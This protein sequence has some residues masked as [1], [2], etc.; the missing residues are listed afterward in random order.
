MNRNVP[1]W[2]P[3]DGSPGGRKMKEARMSENEKSGM[4]RSA[5]KNGQ[6]RNLSST[7]GSVTTLVLCRTEVSKE[8]SWGGNAD[9]LEVTA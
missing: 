5:G 6:K 8:P 2:L 1:M 3:V 4:L 7:F 9:L